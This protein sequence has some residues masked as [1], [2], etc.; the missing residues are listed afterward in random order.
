MLII[1]FSWTTPALLVLLKTCTRRDWNWGYA[2]RFRKGDFLQAWNFSPRF[3]NKCGEC[4]GKGRFPPGHP[5][6]RWELS[7]PV[8]SNCTVCHGTGYVGSK[9]VAT[10]ELTADPYKEWTRDIPAADYRNEGFE[11]LTF[12]GAKIN[13][14]TP[15]EFWR[16]WLTQPYDLLWV[17]RFKVVEIFDYSE[18]GSDRWKKYQSQTGGI[19]PLILYPEEQSTIPG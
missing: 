16:K 1:S 10:V 4:E 11:Y 15:D 17:V 9:R 18:F 5:K 2:K 8:D 19:K 12:I 3:R 6:Y 14:Y 13:G 7:N